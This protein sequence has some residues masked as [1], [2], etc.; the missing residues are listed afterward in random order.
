MVVQCKSVTDL[1]QW[2]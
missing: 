1:H 2:A